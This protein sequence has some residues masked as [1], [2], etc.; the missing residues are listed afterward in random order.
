MN[1]SDDKAIFL[2]FFNVCF[3]QRALFYETLICRRRRANGNDFI[4]GQAFEA[5]YTLLNL[6]IF[7]PSLSSN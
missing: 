3:L 6:V 7:D 1:T 4:K 2:H 5:Y